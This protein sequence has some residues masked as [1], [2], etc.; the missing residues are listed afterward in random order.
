[1]SRF[2]SNNPQLVLDNTIKK[3][4]IDASLVHFTVIG[5]GLRVV[6]GGVETD[7]NEI[8]ALKKTDLQS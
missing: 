3:C 2:F 1:M 7:H 8:D 4:C 6:A 5:T